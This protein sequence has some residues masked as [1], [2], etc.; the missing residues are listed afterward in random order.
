MIIIPAA[1]EG[2]RFAEAG[3]TEPKHLIPLAGIPMIRWV[4]ENIG[5]LERDFNQIV[6]A[7]QKLVGQT[8]GAIDTILKVNDWYPV[9]DDG[10]LVIA[11][12]D[13]LIAYEPSVVD[14]PIGNGLIFT[15]KSANPAHS[16][17][18]GSPIRDIIEKPN[19]P[20]AQGWNDAVS[21]V[22]VFP[23][24]APFMDACRAVRE[25]FNGAEQYVSAALKK[26]IAAGYGLYSQD[27]P[28]AIL[29]TP[30]DFQ[31]FETAAKIYEAMRP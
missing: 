25:E 28:T 20:A 9:P 21:G 22:Y 14:Q 8:K 16:Y 23:R 3:Y 7:D 19:D 29:G 4:L 27:A 11:N 31:R 5:A 24:A 18:S 30:E 17:V 15:F 26:M 13:Q 12:C 10:W 2:R 1:G 6:V